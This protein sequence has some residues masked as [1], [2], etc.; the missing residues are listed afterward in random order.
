MSTFISLEEF[1]RQPGDLRLL[2]ADWLWYYNRAKKSFDQYGEQG[3]PIGSAVTTLVNGHCGSIGSIR[4]FEGAYEADVRYFCIN[5]YE[6]DLPSLVYRNSWWM[7]ITPGIVRSIP[8][9]Y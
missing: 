1:L 9:K 8:W 2:S 7:E 4:K 6:C 5:K 3:P